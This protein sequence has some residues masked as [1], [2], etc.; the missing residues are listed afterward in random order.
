MKKIIGFFSK[1]EDVLVNASVIM[2]VVIALV[3]VIQVVARSMGI[4]MSGT[5]E[6]ARIAYVCF[7]FML[8]PVSAR[9]GNDLRITIVYD[10]IPQRAREIIMGC[11]NIVMAVF[12]IVC[13]YSLKENIR[14]D[15][16]SHLPLPSNPWLQWSVVHT[17]L[18]VC[19]VVAVIATLIRAFM[20]FAGEEHII[21]QTEENEAEMKA[22]SEEIQAELAK[23]AEREKEMEGGNK[24]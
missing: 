6:L 13:V 1:V 4:S 23:D 18:L 21:T 15:K 10:L 14:I 22:A 8:W 5:E 17:I 11:F 3:I 20:L 2:L 9:R 19:M 24:A 16:Q 12:N 7:V